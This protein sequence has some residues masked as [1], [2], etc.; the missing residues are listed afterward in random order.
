MIDPKTS[1]GHTMGLMYWQIGDFWQAPTSSTV[2]YELKWKMAHYYVQNM[3]EF[4]YPLIV[5]QP[6]LANITDE[7]AQLSFYVVN[8]LFT[9]VKGQL[10]CSLVPVDQFSVRLSFKFDVSIDFPTVR[11]VIDLPYSAI[12]RTAGCLNNS[13]CVLHCHLNNNKKFIE[14]TLFLTQPKNYELSQ[15]NLRIEKLEQITSTD[16][17]I[18]LT[19]TNPALFVW[20]DVPLNI[21]GYFSQN[22]FHMFQS[23]KFITFHSWVPMIN[24]DKTD[25]DL[26]ITSLFDTTQS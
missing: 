18:T 12:M 26:R 17:S 15:P 5:L 4:V 21:S 14:Q 8:E 24:L 23:M 22:G 10:M 7:K 20:L 25:F 16:V 11:H 9:G 2:E 1:Q 6:Y 13:Q 3:Y 19:A